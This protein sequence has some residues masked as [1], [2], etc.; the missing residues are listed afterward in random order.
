MDPIESIDPAKDS[1]FVIMLEAQRR[2]HEVYTGHPRELYT[3]GVRV[4]ARLFPVLVG[5]GTP[6]FELQEPRNVYLDE[7]E[8]VFMRKDPPF[9]MDYVFST[10]ILDLLDGKTLVVNDP[11]GIKMANEKMYPLRFPHLVPRTMVT[12]SI[13]GLKAFLEELGGRMIVKPWDGNGGRGVLLLSKDDRNL[14]SLLEM[15]TSDETRHVVAQQYL[16][17]IRSG[18]KRVILIDGRARGAILRI[19]ADDE[20]RGNMHVGARVESCDLTPRDLEI[21]DALAPSLRRDGL[22][23]TGIDIIGGYLIEVNVTS[24]TGIQEINAFHG[25]CLEAEILDHVEQCVNSGKKRLRL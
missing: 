10:Y 16:P 8:A 2:G 18:D 22:L 20:H 25:T 17:D 5:R 6:H 12:R 3:D 21:C 14:N 23:F 9:D 15:S 19:P 13:V 11:A 4:G 1:S 7:M 24:P